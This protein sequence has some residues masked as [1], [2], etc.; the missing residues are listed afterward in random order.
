MCISWFEWKVI[1]CYPEKA[2]FKTNYW[3]IFPHTAWR[4][5]IWYCWLGT[6]MFMIIEEKT[7]K[8]SWC[9]ILTFL[10]KIWCWEFINN[11]I[12]ISPGYQGRLMVFNLAYAQP[13]GWR[14]DEFDR[15]LLLGPLRI[16][17]DAFM[18]QICQGLISSKPDF[19]TRPRQQA[20][21]HFFRLPYSVCIL[22]PPL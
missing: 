5:T 13:M 15:H 11:I 9:L 7:E 21:D 10:R 1:F 19:S 2:L 8:S 18:V 17:R 22:L 16:P 20:Q 4:F 12:Q 6:I 14:D 3:V